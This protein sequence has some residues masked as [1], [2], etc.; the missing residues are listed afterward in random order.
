MSDLDKIF[1]PNKHVNNSEVNFSALILGIGILLFGVYLGKKIT[2]ERKNKIN[3]ST[4]K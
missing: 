2:E 4:K 1:G 3:N